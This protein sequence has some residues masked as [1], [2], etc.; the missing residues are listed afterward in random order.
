M[1]NLNNNNFDLFEK[2]KNRII[3]A[4]NDEIKK[5]PRSR[6]AKLRFAVRNKNKFSN[7]KELK[8]KFNYLIKLEGD[9]A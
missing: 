5:N 8:L 9:N 2:Y 1:P 3:T 6:S 4:S 7:P